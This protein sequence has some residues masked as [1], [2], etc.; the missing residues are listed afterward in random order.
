M[1]KQD[2]LIDQVLIELRKIVR[3]I[4]IHS[5]KLI[6]SFGLTV[7]Q[8]IVLKAIENDDSPTVGEI[9]NSVSLS[10]ATITNIVTRLEQRGYVTRTQCENDKRRVLVKTTEK[11]RETIKQAPSLLH[12]QFTSQFQ[13]LKKWE[14][15]SIIASLQRVA[16][17]MDAQDIEAS[18]VLSPGSIIASDP[19]NLEEER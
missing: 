14:Q 4:D 15:L 5:R 17:M 12:D 16:E 8:I 10:Q 1:L 2:E 3:A 19:V 6:K 18:P 9:A 13:N 7:P 11:G